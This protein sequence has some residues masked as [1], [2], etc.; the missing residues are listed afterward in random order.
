MGSISSSIEL[1]DNFT[2]ILMNVINAVSMSVSTME[3]M[4]SVMNGSIDTSAIQGIRDQMNQATIAAQQLDAAM[5]NISEPQM[6]EPPTP[7]WVNQSTIQV[8]TNT[9]IKH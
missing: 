1:Q 3:Q 2:S 7:S 6:Q 4:Q 8:S 9:G 5:Q